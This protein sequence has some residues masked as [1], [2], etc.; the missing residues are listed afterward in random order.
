MPRRIALAACLALM[1]TTTARAE[2]AAPLVHP[3]FAH[4]PDAPEDDRARQDFTSAATHY[5]LRPVEVVD[6]P[7]PPPPHG[8]DDARLGILNA[9]KMAFTEAKRDLDAAATEAAAT[10]GAGFST[11]DLADLYLHRAMATA[12]SDWKALAA[13][14]ATD[15]RTHAF[16][17]YLRVATLMPDRAANA[18][19][20]PP[21]ALAD[22]QRALDIVHKRPRGTLV[23]KG[24]ADALIA[25][26]GGP[27]QPLGGGV[28]FKDLVFGEHLLRVEQIGFT[29]WGTAIPFGQPEMEID[30][31][32]RAPLA[33]D[34]ATAAAHARRM[35]AR[36][37]LVAT[38]KGGPGAPVEL[39]LIDS[40][41]AVPR[42][43]SLVATRERGQ[44]DAAVMRLD[45]EARRLT[46]EQQQNGVGAVPVA[47]VAAADGAALGP[48]LLLTP[49]GQKARLRDDPAA[50]ARDRWPLLT[51]IGAFALT[52][53]VLSAVVASD[54]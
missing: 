54:R 47:P 37:A 27:L 2:T 1:S 7:A 10:G 46:L 12:R 17:D 53:V 22:L 43:A 9:Q 25:L 20:L 8:P 14:P 50:W 33:L 4:L 19:Q 29:P 36:Y 44:M 41:T 6:V 18:R 15:E 49:A 13:A 34:A 35:G 23:V 21:Q 5:N 31:P 45:E 39:S 26:D 32:A 48:P 40:A 11:A 28:T 30:V 3:I 16:D 38:A 24:P 42:D 52:A 51:A